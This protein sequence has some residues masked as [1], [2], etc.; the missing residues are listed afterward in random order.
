[1]TDPVRTAAIILAAGAGSRFGGDKLL[2]E[3]GGRSLLEHVVRT[4]VAAGLSPTVVVVGPDALELEAIASGRGAQVVRNPRPEDGLSSSVQTALTALAGD[5]YDALDAALVL[6]GDQPRTSLATIQALLAADVPAGRSIVI[7]RYAGGG[8]A[9]PV[10]LLR[11]AWPL[12][13]RLDGDRG[14]GP[15]IRERPE[16][17]VEVDLP[18]DNPDVDTPSDLARIVEAAWADRVTAN[19]E[20]VE[21][22]R[23]VPDGADFYAPVRSLFRADPTRTDDPVLAALLALVQPGDRWLD[24]GAGA[25]RFA[26]PLAR[27]L[28][29]SGGSVVALDGSPSMLESL[30]EIAADYHIRNVGTVEA[31]WPPTAANALE[32]EPADVVLIAHVGYDVAGIGPFVDALEASARRACVAVLMDRVPASAADPFWPLVHDQARDQ[33]PALPEFLELLRA[34]GRRVQLVRVPNDGRLFDSR[35]VLEGFV[36]RQLW[37]DRDGPKEARF[38]AALDKLALEGDGGWAIAGRAPN[39]IGVVSWQP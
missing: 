37:I 32:T 35:A 31:R 38:Q 24:V 19:R 33:L 2:A 18:G 1:M 16:L 14:F 25:G 34:R 36:R 15:L 5:D 30:R 10:L 23:E 17:V 13:A 22:I 9:N 11:A 28:A 27:A 39:Q 21:R 4:A 7:P 6:L 8:G 12:A 3:L 29:A 20:Q 26:L